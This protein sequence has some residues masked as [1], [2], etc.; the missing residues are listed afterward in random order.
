MDQDTI[1]FSKRVKDPQWKW[2]H[3][4]FFINIQAYIHFPHKANQAS[5]LQGFLCS[6]SIHKQQMRSCLLAKENLENYVVEREIC[7]S[8]IGVVKLSRESHHVR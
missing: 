6:L 2:K 1:K 5:Y 8:T 4:L 7:L 3:L